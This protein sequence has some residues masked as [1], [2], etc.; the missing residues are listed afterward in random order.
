VTRLPAPF[1]WWDEHI[2]AEAPGG[3]VLFTTRRGGVSRGPYASLN[4]GLAGA[5]GQPADDPEAVA[6][7]RARLA[8]R[9]GIP[10]ERIWRGRQVHGNRV[11]SPRRR[12]PRSE[13]RP[14]LARGVEPLAETGVESRP[15]RGV[16]PLPEAD[17][18]AT[19][20]GDEAAA[21]L[22]ADCLPVA[23]VG[24]GAVAMLHCGWRGLAAGILAE[25]VEALRELGDGPLV[26]LI[27][28][29]A[30]PCCYEVGPEVHEALAG[31]ADSGSAEA[32]HVPERSAGAVTGAP[33]TVDLKA[34]A[35]ERLA[36]AGVSEIHDVGLCTICGDPALF[37]SHRRD[38]GV[39]GRQCGVVWRA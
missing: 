17:G 15:T 11:L 25:G 4:L 19:D 20:R 34:F 30:G 32:G 39:T 5:D 1:R 38:G 33:R 22:V 28:P 36:D 16:E 8:E 26:A 18:H 24:P 29:G 37:F 10:W 23:L 6:V 35:A 12:A 7:N 14:G 3:R 27:G 21:V 9:V 31:G 13:L 2:A